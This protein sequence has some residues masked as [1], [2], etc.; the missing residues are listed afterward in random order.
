MLHELD[1]ALVPGFL[2]IKVTLD[3]VSKIKTTEGVSRAEEK[4]KKSAVYDFRFS[5]IFWFFVKKY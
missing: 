3:V 2:L 4:C 1:T 5:Y